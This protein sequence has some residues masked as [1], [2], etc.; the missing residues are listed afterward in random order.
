MPSLWLRAFGATLVATITTSNA[1]AAQDMPVRVEAVRLLERAN[2]V[3]RPS[4][5]MSN[6][7]IETTFRAYGLEGSTKEG[8]E[9]HDLRAL[10]EMHS[11]RNGD[12][13]DS[14][15]RMSFAS[16]PSKVWWCAGMLETS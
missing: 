4:H 16:I 9:S 10:G 12:R 13:G 3:S 14:G 15:K 11:F 8:Q 7:K 1:R 5:P 2:L 6:H